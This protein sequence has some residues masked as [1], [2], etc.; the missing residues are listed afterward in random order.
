MITRS[1]FFTLLALVI[2]TPSLRAQTYGLWN[3]IGPFDHPAGAGDLDTQELVERALK[4]MGA[5]KD[6]PDLRATFKGRTG[7]LG[8]T[9][10]MSGADAGRALDVGVIDLVVALQPASPPKDWYSNALAYIYRRIDAPADTDVTVA[11]GSDDGMR[12]WFNGELLVDRGV[13]R[14]LNVEDHLLTLHFKPGANHLLVKIS[15]AGGPWSFRMSPWKR[16][17]QAAIDKAIDRGVEYLL[18]TQLL[19]GTWGTHEEWGAGHTSFACYT[20]LECGVGKADPAVRMALSAMTERPSNYTY[21]AASLVM[22]LAK[23]EDPARKDQ[24]KRALDDL[25]KWQGGAQLLSY[26]V[27]V[28]GRTVQADLSNT[29]YCALAYR[30]A[31]QAGFKVPEKVW[32]E[33]ADGTLTCLTHETD[34]GP[35]TGG[36]STKSAG[37]TYRIGEGEPTGSITTAGLSVL[38]LAQEGLQGKVPPALRSRINIATADGLNWIDQRFTWYQN[39]GAGGHHYFWIYGLERVGTLL[40]L[41]M[42]GGVEWYWAGAA[43]LV[44]EQK[45]NGAWSSSTEKEEPIDTLL[46]LLFLKRATTTM[47]VDFTPS[48]RKKPSEPSTASATV[49]SGGWSAGADKDDVSIH[50]RGES[51]TVLWLSGLREEVAKECSGDKGLSVEKIEFYGRFA[52]EKDA[53]PA[54]LGTLSGAGLAAPISPDALARHELAHQFDRRGAWI[55]SASLFLKIATRERVVTSPDLAFTI[56]DVFDTRR[57]E[58]AGDA[59]RSLLHEVEPRIEASSSAEKLT[60]AMAADGRHGT[61]WQCTPKDITPWIRFTIAKGLSAGRVLLSHAHPRVLSA[62]EARAGTVEVIVNGEQKLQAVMDPDVRMKTV[63]DLAQYT[64]VRT[65]EVRIL[66]AR[67]GRLGQSAVGFS[68]IEL[69]PAK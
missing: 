14:A 49:K 44:K 65:L 57:L 55:V 54:L 2:L 7:Q 51:P 35:V 42:L 56:R 38:A 69:V 5:G 58:Y 63:V 24:L 52:G 66:D 11:A 8:W 21:S 36:H 29:L 23:L 31:S 18:D 28:D 10:L 9:A 13:L 34:T 59:A 67:D 25:L 50:A 47:T 20:L 48:K 4:Q 15:N 16:I 22:A 30:A 37:F 45:K 6:G 1:R 62:D 19:D 39:P 60:P 41:S 3:A 32:T 68:E 64:T 40:D 61:A 12:L 53:A 33:L 46:A 27:Y 26:P 17:D 43:Y